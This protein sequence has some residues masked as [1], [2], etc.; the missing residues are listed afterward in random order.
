MKIVTYLDDEQI[1]HDNK[2]YDSVY[3]QVI[4]MIIIQ[5]ISVIIKDYYYSIKINVIVD[6]DYSLNR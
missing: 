1:D 3:N 2:E 4:N 6:N 5:C